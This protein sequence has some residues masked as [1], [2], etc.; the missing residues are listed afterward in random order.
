MILF[1][2]CYVFISDGS[3]GVV[4]NECKLSYDAGGGAEA[5]AQAK[6]GYRSVGVP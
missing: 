1:F 5:Q 6:E 3:V 4:M 2:F